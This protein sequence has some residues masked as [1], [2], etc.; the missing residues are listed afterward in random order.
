MIVI[1]VHRVQSSCGFSIPF[2][3]YVGERPVLPPASW[4]QILKVGQI[5]V[6]YSDFR[7]APKTLTAE[8]GP[9]G[10][11]DMGGG[12]GGK[13]SSACCQTSEFRAF[14]AFEVLKT[15]L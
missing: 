4:S 15:R 6:R 14:R 8:E 10:E 1:D 11:E 9:L 7:V 3:D 12:I 5:G 2:Y 13:S